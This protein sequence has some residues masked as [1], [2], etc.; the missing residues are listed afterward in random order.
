MARVCVVIE[1]DAFDKNVTGVYSSPQQAM[2]AHGFPDES[3]WRHVPKLSAW[4]KQIGDIKV[5]IDEWP[6]I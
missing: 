5:T 6:V 1:Q 3:D 4:E 2:K